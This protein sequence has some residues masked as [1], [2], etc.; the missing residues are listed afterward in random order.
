MFY[1]SEI[2]IVW[3]LVKYFSLEKYLF[4]PTLPDDQGRREKPSTEDGLAST[5]YTAPLVVN[6]ENGGEKR[7]QNEKES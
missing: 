6:V 5:N 1:Y 2:I 7:R 4:S 3:K